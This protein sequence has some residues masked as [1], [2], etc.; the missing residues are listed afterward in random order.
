MSK[1]VG[2]CK[3]PEQFVALT[4]CCY[5]LTDNLVDSGAIVGLKFPAKCLREDGS[6]HY[7][8]KPSQSR[9]SFCLS[10]PEV[11]HC[12]E[13]LAEFGWPEL[14]KCQCVSSANVL[15]ACGART[16]CAVQGISV[17]SSKLCVW[18]CVNTN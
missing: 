4:V 8:I 11:S 6:S 17:S 14:E 7:A 12:N 16:E 1:R 18:K 10:S 3:H 5:E 13:Q 15:P 2:L 9:T